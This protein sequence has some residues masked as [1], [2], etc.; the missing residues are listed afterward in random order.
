[1]KLW[2]NKLFEEGS[3]GHWFYF[4]I[5]LLLVIFILWILLKKGLADWAKAGTFWAMI[6]E[7]GLMLLTIAGFVVFC[8]IDP[9]DVFRFLGAILLFVWNRL[10]Y[11]ILRMIFNLQ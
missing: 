4:V 8:Y 3:T 10:L 11:P 9:I 6:E 2:I 1:M 5:A 7:F